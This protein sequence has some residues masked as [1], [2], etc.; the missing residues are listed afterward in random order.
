MALRAAQSA[1]DDDWNDTRQDEIK[2]MQQQQGGGQA[3]ANSSATSDEDAPLPD[4]PGRSPFPPPPAGNPHTFDS[5]APK[6][7]DTWQ[8]Q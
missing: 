5:W 1:Q 4:P 2:Q 8:E 6:L 3:H 7:G